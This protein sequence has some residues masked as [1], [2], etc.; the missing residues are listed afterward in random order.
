VSAPSDQV[1]AFSDV[2][3]VELGERVGAGAC[4]SLLAQLGANVVFVEPS[5]VVPQLKWINRGV[6]SAGKRSVV[7]TNN[8]KEFLRQMLECADVVLLSSDVTCIPKWQRSDTQ[9]VCDLTAV[10]NTG[11]LRGQP[12][13]DALVQ[14]LSGVSDTT[15]HPEGP[16]AFVG[17]PI[18]EFSAGVYAAA[19]VVAALRVCRQRGCGQDIDIALFDCAISA[20]AT[21][22][23]FPISGKSVSRSG[24]KHSLA[25]PWNAYCA[26]DG[27]V[28]ICTATDE[29]WAR[30]CKSIGQTQLIH[31]DGYSTNPQRVTNTKKV[32]AVV[33]NWTKSRNV[34]ECIECL[35]A[36]GI[37]C[38][39]ILTVPQ[40]QT[41]ENLIHR[42]M[43]VRLRNEENG[44][45]Q[46]LPGSPLRASKTPGRSP[47]R[48]PARDSGRAELEALLGSWVKRQGKK[49][50]SD[51]R[52]AGAFADLRV[53]EIGQYTTAPLVSRQFAALGAEVIKLEPPGGE[54]SRHWPPHQGG[55]GYF[56]TF[57]NS[58]KRS[59]TLDLRNK[60]DKLLFRSLL[61]STDVLVENLKP[62]SLEKLGFNE[63]ELQRINPRLVY[64]AI[65]GFGLKSIYPGRPAFDTVV[66]AMCGFM[67]LTR[68]GGMPMKSGIS[69]AD[70]MGGEIALLAIMA[71][72][73]YRDSS[74]QG[75]SIDISMQDAGVWAT[76]LEW[77]PS[78]DLLC[79]VIREC[80]DGYAAL[81]GDTKT[82]RQFLIEQGLDENN[83]RASGLTR[84]ELVKRAGHSR[85]I[86]APVNNVCE[87]LTHQQVM[88]RQLILY[89]E[90]PDELR[91]PL[92]NSPLR[93]SLTPPSVLRPIGRLG[94][95]N[96]DILFP[97]L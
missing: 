52:A 12:F 27:W 73:F 21:F 5:E 83:S 67:D 55:Q 90:S 88:D 51:W 92:L 59:I 58:D 37:A 56:F 17:L 78:N 24:N 26:A 44:I 95:A 34:A 20:L 39:P 94:E 97:H 68:V 96:E 62:G 19:A 66:Q 80:K 47:T 46:W 36:I 41:H 43:I 42:E 22:L 31:E 4:G 63:A 79:T 75:Q 87:I 10:G 7:I 33:E 49:M 60:N 61:K 82:L 57:S 54:G 48:I 23:P 8:D 38:G 91:W 2:L 6:M 1:T 72:I 93:L 3:V 30:L 65:S 69:A 35:S 18:L 25:S 74:N 53:V 81:N 32:D 89:K 40:L 85:L 70:I 9:I 64:C 15:G 76:Q 11:P 14:A 84:E 86:G 16:P 13:S 28:L 29:Q 71:A 50:A 45:D 77:Q